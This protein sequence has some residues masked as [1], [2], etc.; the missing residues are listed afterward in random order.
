MRIH[1]PLPAPLFRSESQA[2]V[3]AALF[4]SNKRLTVQEL[5]KR[6][7]IPYSTIHRE[8]SRLLASELLTEDRVGNY[9]F[10]TPNQLSPLY[11]PLT[12]LLEALSGPIPLLQKELALIPE[13]EW[14]AL[15]G[16]WAQ[17]LLGK[18]GPQPHDVDVL[19]VG[20]PE[21]RQVNKACSAVSK[22]LGWEVNPVILTSSEWLEETPFLRQVRKDGLVPIIGIEDW[23]DAHESKTSLLSST[24][25]SKSSR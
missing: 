10:F 5:S 8:I 23:R 6:T 21:I 4:L 12:D 7:Q 9:R 1:S 20:A 2:S 18:T 15:F 16:S 13:I 3:L 24:E 22:T 11:R 17:R 19:I 14:V 25:P